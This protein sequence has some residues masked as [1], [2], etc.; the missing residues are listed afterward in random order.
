MSEDDIAVT[1][2]NKSRRSD[3]AK[4]RRESL[5][6]AKG[7]FNAAELANVLAQFENKLLLDR[8]KNLDQKVNALSRDIAILTRC[9]MEQMHAVAGLS[10]SI[11]ELVNT[12]SSSTT[13]DMVHADDSGDEASLSFENSDEAQPDNEDDAIDEVPTTPAVN[14]FVN[15]P[16]DWN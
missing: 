1:T 13:P 16:K 12:L 9:F 15:I 2:K 11:D 4:K 5:F 3:S 7:K 6:V 14:V 10:L 8:I